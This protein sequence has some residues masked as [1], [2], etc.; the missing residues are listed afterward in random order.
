M[1][2]NE[3]RLP[4]DHD[5]QRLDDPSVSRSKSLI[6][7]RIVKRTFRKS[8]LVAL[9]RFGMKVKWSAGKDGDKS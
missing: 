3:G 7:L 5:S 1:I 9:G 6:V 2:G 4:N 8:F